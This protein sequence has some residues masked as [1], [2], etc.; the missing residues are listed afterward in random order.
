MVAKAIVFLNDGSVSELKNTLITLLLLRF[1]FMGLFLENFKFNYEYFG[2][3]FY[4]VL[5]IFAL[6]NF[7][8]LLKIDKYLRI[9]SLIL[10]V[11]ITYNYWHFRGTQE[12]LIFSFVLILFKYLFHL[13][14]ENKNTP[15]T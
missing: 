5:Y 1:T 15:S 6:F 3:M 9:I 14:V 7:L 10:L 8:T 11:L 13:I 12:I 4:L 2:R